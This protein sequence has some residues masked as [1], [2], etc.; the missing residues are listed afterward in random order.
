MSIGRVQ[1]WARPRREGRAPACGQALACGRAVRPRHT[2]VRQRAD[3]AGP[4]R[5]LPRAASPGRAAGPRRLGAGNAAGAWRRGGHCRGPSTATLSSTA[6]P[7]RRAAARPGRGPDPDP[8]R[9]SWPARAVHRR[10]AC[11]T[12]TPAA[13]PGQPLRRRPSPLAAVRAAASGPSRPHSRAAP[14]SCRRLQAR[15]L[16]LPAAAARACGCRLGRAGSG[17]HRYS[18]LRC[19]VLKTI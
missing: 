5:R 16:R 1:H 15:A 11:G 2:L 10:P 9:C 19:C 14:Y 8:G 13:V 12:L 7:W 4:A 17:R 6:A 18:R 3:A